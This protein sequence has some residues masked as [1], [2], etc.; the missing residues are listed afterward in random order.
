MN[1]YIWN[2]YRSQEVTVT[3]QTGPCTVYEASPSGNNL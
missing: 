1:F 2:V 3:V